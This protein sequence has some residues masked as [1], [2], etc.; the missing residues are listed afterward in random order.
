[1]LLAIQVPMPAAMIPTAGIWDYPVGVLGLPRLTELLQHLGLITV[2]AFAALPAER[3]ITRFGTQAGAA[4][5]T[6]RGL[7]ARP[8][9]VRPG[10]DQH[11]VDLAFDRAETNVERLTFAA[12]ALADQLHERSGVRAPGGGRR[13]RPNRAEPGTG[14][15][16]RGRL[17][18]LAVADRVR[19]LVQAWADAGE[20]GAGEEG[21]IIRLVLR[22]EGLGPA[23]GRQQALFREALTPQEVERAAARVQALPG[24]QA[25]TRVEIG[26]GRGPAA[27]IRRI[28]YGDEDTCWRL[29]AG[30]WPVLE[31]WWEAGRA[32]RIARM[33]VTTGDARAWLLVIEE[34][35]W[36]G[37]VRVAAARADMACAGQA[38]CPSVGG[39]TAGPPHPL[40]ATGPPAQRPASRPP[41]RARGRPPGRAR[42]VH[43]RFF[44]PPAG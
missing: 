4:H 13:P 39:S 33:Q 44:A 7:E 37:A 25:V 15:P 17:S 5:R 26:G 2:G 1:M 16:P 3:V 30:P 38:R 10:G 27:Q 35:R 34:S 9:T 40:S 20:L 18:A 43:D 36:Q 21:G 12:K 28:P 19:G 31:Q 11:V 6:A 42:G 32:R 24:H 23:S 14:L 29:P 8:L 41:S 22:P